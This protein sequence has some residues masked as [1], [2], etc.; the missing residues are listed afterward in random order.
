MDKEIICKCPFAKRYCGSGRQK[1]QEQ[2]RKENGTLKNSDCV[3]FK[4]IIKLNEV[5]GKLC[6]E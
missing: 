5:E 3:F 1:L 6:N 2:F 4:T